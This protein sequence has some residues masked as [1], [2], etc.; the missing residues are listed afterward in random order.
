MG[1]CRPGAWA[2]IHLTPGASAVIHL[3][4]SYR[5]ASL[6]I[7]VRHMPERATTTCFP[8]AEA[9]CAFHD[10]VTVP[11]ESGPLRGWPNLPK[12]SPG[13][14]AFRAAWATRQGFHRSWPSQHDRPDLHVTAFDRDRA[15]LA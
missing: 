8:N 15:K 12:D 2:V 9:T 5:D 7:I 1:P 3:R 10:W 14:D 11:I 4:P 6:T 13:A